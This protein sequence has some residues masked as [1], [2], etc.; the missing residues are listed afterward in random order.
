V[1]YPR[2]N[3]SMNSVS[4][5]S[6]ERPQINADDADQKITAFMCVNLWLRRQ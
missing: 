1:I 3:G 2:P 6:R 5:I 4:S